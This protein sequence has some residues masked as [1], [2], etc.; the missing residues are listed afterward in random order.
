MDARTSEYDAIADVVANI[1]FDPGYQG[2]LNDYKVSLVGGIYKAIDGMGPQHKDEITKLRS[3]VNEIK[4]AKS[5]GE[6]EQIMRRKGAIAQK[7]VSVTPMPGMDQETGLIN[8]VPG[9]LGDVMKRMPPGT[10]VEQVIGDIDPQLK[11]ELDACRTS[12]DGARSAALLSHIEAEMPAYVRRLDIDPV[13]K[14]AIDDLC[15][16]GDDN[17]WALSDEEGPD[18]I[19]Q[20]QELAKKEDR[21]CRDYEAILDSVDKDDIKKKVK[22]FDDKVIDEGV[23]K[24]IDIM[25]KAFGGDAERKRIEDADRESR[26]I[27]PD[28]LG[29]SVTGAGSRRGT[30]ADRG[31]D[32]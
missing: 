24:V 14:K 9:M 5:V 3:T 26:G 30:S 15:A 11:S 4:D 16:L 6:I 19:E 28:I 21:S 22:H 1:L 10:S 32:A 13:I 8:R 25:T 18:L 12:G 31:K 29:P 2:S 27:K 7:I 17:A 23:R 20:L